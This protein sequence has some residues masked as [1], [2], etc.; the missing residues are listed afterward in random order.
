[1]KRITLSTVLFACG[2]LATSTPLFAQNDSSKPAEP[3]KTTEAAKAPEAAP[4]ADWFDG[5]I[6]TYLL[7]RDDVASAKFQEYQIVPRGL[8]VPFF[9]LAGS[10]K[11]TDFAFRAKNVFQADQRYTGGLD[12]DYLGL[13]F[14]F[15][16]IPHNMGYNGEAF[17]TETAPGVWSM[18]AMLRNSL[19]NVVEATPTANRTYAFYNN[20]LSGTMAAAGTQDLS[21]LR[22]R[23]QFTANLGDKLPFNLSFTYM[24]DEKTGYRGESGGD[25]I[26]AV[27][28]AVD[29]LEPMDEV[30]QDFGLRWAVNRKQG[31]LYASFNHNVY[32]DRINQ[33][34]IDNPF[35]ATDKLVTGTTT[36][37]GGP[38]Q[39]LFSTLPDNQ[40]NRGAFG[41]QFKFKRQTRITADVALSQ[42]TQNAQFLPFTLNTAIFTPSGVPA[43]ST[44][45]L[46]QQSL[47]G[48]IDT[49]SFNVGFSS[50]PVQN[51]KVS[52]RFR[53]YDLTNKTTPISWLAGS[54]SGNPDRSWTA[55]TASADAPYG[56]ATANMY[57]N[58]SKR[59]DAHV[60]Y[61]IKDL[62]LEAGFRTAA[63]T[64]TN[65]EATTGDDNGYGLSA[66]YNTMDWLAFRAKYDYLHRTA[67]GETVYGFQAD[68]AERKTDR[69]GLDVEITP[70]AKYGFTVAYYRL[71][72]DYPNRP[73]RVQVSGGV[74]VAGAQPIPGT[75]SGLL[76]SKYDE[77]TVEF[78]LSPTARAEF[79]AYY[80][81]EKSAQTNQW[82]TTTGAKLNNLLNYAGS[83]KGNTF[84]LTAAFQLVPQ[85]WT[86]SL[87][88]RHQKV[89][90]LM[91]ITANESGAFYASRATVIPPGTGGAA[92]ITNFDDTQLTTVVADLAHPVGKGW[93]FNVGYAYDKYTVA[94]AFT[95]GTTIFPQSVL[96]YMKTNDGNYKANIA[97]TRMTYRF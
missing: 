46:P 79:N 87:M 55:V 29:V 63:L 14:D 81:Y 27:T 47:N 97:Y 58:S 78:D 96:F 45:A 93:T 90:G 88:A 92:D 31:N 74:P 10:Q 8:S 65:R 75:P 28:S 36:T 84:G 42:W 72:N 12:T 37:S 18:S 9:N 38:A 57:D 82:S 26:G 83:D 48:K 85:K 39:A 3:A 86:A 23:G 60:G 7:G 52:L 34:V 66:V 1:M 95:D 24:R 51:V 49:T 40:A 33:L 44:A 25:I 94:D 6:S 53:S 21:G 13:S 62:T 41:A 16:Q 54:T 80:T 67:H 61:D 89:N 11:G 35:R 77:Y 64:R 70:S 2:L 91:D 43:N 76:N 71:N 50:R 20:I 73:D 4:T 69:V 30:T 32:N 19:A 59:F 17:F 15:N 22:Q 56:F 68:E 5:N